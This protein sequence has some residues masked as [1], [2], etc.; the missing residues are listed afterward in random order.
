MS[1]WRSPTDAERREDY[2]HLVRFLQPRTAAI[3]ASM[4]VVITNP[5]AAAPF[6]LRADAW[7]YRVD[8]L[9]GGDIPTREVAA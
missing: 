1:A 5:E 8:R 7:C 6:A 2:F 9:L 3:V 4:P